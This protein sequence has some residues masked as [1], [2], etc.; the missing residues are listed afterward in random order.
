MKRVTLCCLSLM[1]GALI[2]APVQGFGQN[3]SGYGA[4]TGRVTDP[5]GAVVPEATVT[6][7]DESTHTVFSTK[8]NHVGYYTFSDVKPSTYDLTVTRPGFQKLVIAQ[9]A[10]VVGQSLTLNAKLEVGSTAQVVQITTTPGAELQTLNSTIGTSL[11]GDTILQ[12]PTFGRDATSLLYFQPTAVP[13]FNGATGDITSGTVAGQTSDQNTYSID[14]GNAT[15]DFSGGNDYVSNGFTVGTA[16]IP[17]PVESIQEFKVTTSNA[18]ADFSDS[19][20]GHVMLVTKSGTNQFHGSAYDYLQNSAL[21]TNDWSNNFGGTPKPVSKYDR[22]GGALGGP[23]LPRIGGNRTYFYV[24][25]EGFRWPRTSIYSA[26]VPSALFRQGIIQ[27]K[28]K[29]GNIVQYNMKTS[30]ACGATGGVLCDPL[31]I[32]LNPDIAKLW[33][34]HEPLPNYFNAGDHMNT[35]AY[36]APVSIPESQNFVV[37]RIDHDFSSKLRW[38]ASYRWYDLQN[39]TTNQVDIGGLLPGDKLGV[40]TA[41]SQDPAHPRYFVT[42]LTAT[43]TPTVTNDFHFSFLRNQWQWLR[44]GFTPQVAGLTAPIEVGG[45]ST[46]ALIPII[47]RTQDARQ[48]LWDGHDWDYRDNLSWMKGTHFFQFGGEFMHDWWHFDR[49][50][51]VTG[52]LANSVVDQITAGSTINFSAPNTPYQPIPCSAAVTTNCLPSSELGSWKNLYAEALGIVDTDNFV[53]TRSGNNLTPNPVGTPVHQYALDDYYSLF[54]SDSW[55]VRPSVTFNL[56]LAYTYQTPPYDINGLQNVLTDSS[57]SILT[58]EQYLQG[59]LSAAQNGQTYAPIIGYTPVRDVGGAGG[60]KYPYQPFYGGFEPRVAIAWSPSVSGGWLGKILGNQTTVI[61]GGFARI[62]DRNNAINLMS[63]AVLGDGFLQPVSCTGPSTTGACLGVG[64]T[65]PAT[66][67]RIGIN[68]T[69]GPLPAITPTLTI[70]VEPGY[71]DASYIGALSAGLDYHMP[72][73]YS[74]EIDFSIQRQLKGNFLVEV[75]YV[76]NYTYNIYQG[77]DLNDAPWMM[78]LKGQTFA[79]AYDNLWKE[80]TNGTAV[81]TQPFFEGALAG[82]PYCTGYANCT[83]AVAANESGNITTESVT[84]LWSDLD[85]SFAFGPQLLST[86]QCNICYYSTALGFSN[87]NALTATVQKRAGN[88]LTLSS[89]FTYSHALGTVGLE[90]LYTEDNLDNPW[91]PREN[92]GAQYFDHKAIF[93]VVANYDLPIGPGHRFLASNNPVLKRVFGGWNIAPIFTYASGQPLDF[94]TGSYQEFGAGFA[95]NGAEAVPMTNTRNI[96]NAAHFGITN[97][98]FIGS[99]S[100]PINGGPG[101][102]LFGNNAAQIFNSFAPCLVG[103]CTRA[104]TGGYLR[105]PSLWDLD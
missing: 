103:I 55:R 30:T 54:A 12:L 80:L 24:N 94:Y 69:A 53:V 104:G 74:N 48:R 70:P 7:T 101:V 14:G 88:G 45:E 63:D 15:D 4:V 49:Y 33:T 5:T 61:R 93:N 92:Y 95:E 85:P 17:A 79:N 58:P 71:G 65:S 11:A 37:G 9:Q 57:G 3:A 19:T 18:T 90:Q 21:D 78:K 76:G 1:L 29:S 42:G 6:L 26:T 51:D 43:L 10:V 13:S 32:G 56:G 67:F 72:P 28:D 73:G 46:S 100:T 8:T 97:L 91:N 40:P 44:G 89:S 22:F 82:S 77:V 102:N 47:L 68:G 25:Y 64:G 41:V 66:A 62:Y 75:G 16:A 96:S 81:T 87:Y 60:L 86:T 20:G 35:F 52:G 50:D 34:Q 99:N 27:E 83:A 38:W 84:S 105:G 23:L 59:R 36:R 31:G 39:P 2:L 98:P